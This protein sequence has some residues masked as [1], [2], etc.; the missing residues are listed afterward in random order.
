MHIIWLNI[1][2]S[3]EICLALWFA[4]GKCEILSYS[5]INFLYAQRKKHFQFSSRQFFNINSA[6]NW[7][8][9]LV[10]VKLLKWTKKKKEKNGKNLKSIEVNIKLRSLLQEEEKV[11]AKAGLLS[12][13]HQLKNKIIK[14]FVRNKRKFV[15][16]FKGKNKKI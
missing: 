7:Q 13:K 8:N 14:N 4:R 6:E 1:F 15:E 9:L 12:W 10:T 3:F 16:E 5:L 11:L 2:L